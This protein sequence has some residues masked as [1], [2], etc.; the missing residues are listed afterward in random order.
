MN[1]VTLDTLRALYGTDTSLSAL[2]NTPS[3]TAFAELLAERLAA[4]GNEADM[5]PKWRRKRPPKKKCC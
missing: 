4:D 3:G 2:S 5:P 1:G